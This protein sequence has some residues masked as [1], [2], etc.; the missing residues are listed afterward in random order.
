MNNY[1][2][3][4]IDPAI[5]SNIVTSTA[6]IVIFVFFYF[7]GSSYRSNVVLA[8]ECTGFNNEDFEEI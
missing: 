8:E 3:C 7:H 5:V 4:S 1:D 2:E 6:T